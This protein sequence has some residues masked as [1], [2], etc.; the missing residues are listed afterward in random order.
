MNLDSTKWMSY[1]SDDVKLCDLT[2][3]GTHNT[4]ASKCNIL[5]RCQRLSLMEQLN[6]GVRFIDIRCRHIN[7]EFKLFH[8]R[9][10][11]KYDFENDVL[12]TCA[13][14]LRSNQTETIIMLLKHEYE[15]KNNAKEFYETFLSYTSNYYNYLYLN[16]AMPSLKDARG[17]IVLLRRFKSKK[18]FG[19][20]MSNWSFSAPFNISKDD[21]VKFYIQDM[22]KSRASKKIESIME[23]IRHAEVKNFENVWYLNYAS[24]TKWPFQ[25]P[26]YIA[27]RVKKHL[28]SYLNDLSKSVNINETL[29]KNLGTIIIDFADKVF[30]NQIFM[31]NFF[32]NR[33][34]LKNQT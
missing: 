29:N 24:G 21:E 12:G 27:Y 18:L 1:I 13:Q 6:A 25:P 10:K 15:P 14:F 30:I 3:P 7:D 32:V 20:D 2:I 9:F 16:D 34:V 5:A 17:K 23:M 19:I 33:S 11:I 22:Y 28:N 26:I 31:I 4:C 8:G